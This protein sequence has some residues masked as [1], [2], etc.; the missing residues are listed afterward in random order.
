[1]ST[2]MEWQKISGE[3]KYDNNWIHVA[4]KTEKFTV[5]TLIKY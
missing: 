2:L 3:V 4:E 1:M 5:I